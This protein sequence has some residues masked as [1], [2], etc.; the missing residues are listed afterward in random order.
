MKILR[1]GKNSCANGTTLLNKSVLNG[2][3]IQDFAYFSVAFLAFIIDSQHS[4]IFGHS[5]VLY[6]RELNLKPPYKEDVWNA[7]SADDWQRAIQHYYPQGL[8]TEPNFIDILKI[9]TDQPSQAKDTVL[10]LD[11]FMASIILHGLINVKWYQ[12]RKALGIGTFL[13][14]HF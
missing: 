4:M 3:Y 12:Q 6:A 1:P 11:P 8:I 10:T 14:V 7:E 2:T 9:F 13:A 5:L